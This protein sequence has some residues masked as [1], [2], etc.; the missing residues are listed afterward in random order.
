MDV[1]RRAVWPLAPGDTKHLSEDERLRKDA[2]STGFAIFLILI[3]FVGPAVVLAGGQWLR[4]NTAAT[5]SFGP[6]LDK[7]DGVTSESAVSTTMVVKFSKNGSALAARSSTDTIT[8]DA[9]G[10]YLVPIATTDTNTLGRLRMT[11]TDTSTF[12]SVWQDYMVLPQAV[13]DSLISGTSSLTVIVGQNNDKA[14]YG[15]T[16]AFP[17][18]F[19]AMG[20]S[21]GGAINTVGVVTDSRIANLDASVSSR[22]AA[23]SYT[24]PPSSSDNASA[25][26]AAGTRTLT[27]KSSFTLTSDYDA[28]KTAA[29]AATA[30]STSTWTPTMAGFLDAAISTRLPSS[31]Y[32][33]PPSSS[34]IAGAIWTNGSRSLTDSVT[35]TSAYDAA[36][37]AAQ[38][39]DAMTIAANQ[40]IRNVTGNVAGSVGSVTNSVTLTTA[41]DA[42]KTA[43]QPGDSMT[44]T[45]AYDAAKTCLPASSYTAAPS[46]TDIDSL[47]SANHGAGAWGGGGGGGGSDP[48][49]VNLPGTYTAG[50]AG[51]I[52]GNT[53][54]DSNT[55][56]AFLGSSVPGTYTAGTLAYDIGHNLDATVSSRL[57]A[58]SFTSS[59]T[60]I[61]G[62]LSTPVPGTFPAG[63]LGEIIGNTSSMT[64]IV[65]VLSS[66]S[67]TL[68][69][70]YDAAKEAVSMYD[71]RLAYLDSYVSSCGSSTMSWEALAMDHNMPGTM[72]ALLNG[73]GAG[74]DPLAVST[75]A[76]YAVGTYGYLIKNLLAKEAT[77]LSG[78]S[79]GVI[80]PAITVYQNSDI[81]IFQ[82]DSTTLTISL[83][84][85]WPLTSQTVTL[86]V[87]SSPTSLNTT[88][89]INRVAT[90]TDAAHGIATIGITSTDTHTALTYYYSIFVADTAAPLNKRTA[91][92]GRFIIKPNVL[93]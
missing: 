11:A 90:V 25:T 62:L 35:L 31:S 4:Q 37:T 86:V 60:F 34:T 18:N 68:N 49:A 71:P 41:Y 3:F 51:Y 84:T 32:S 39:G 56:S 79:K 17:V 87:K 50:T 66:G 89:L 82:G 57:P 45:V 48:W 47:L 76:T 29:P 26:W 36:K 92:T 10:Y 73:A 23:A 58:S 93:P 28:A 77:M 24:A 22:L 65:N 53:S 16:Q 21:A 85:A 13:Y 52:I 40:D 75:S 6:F 44:L 91:M 2:N 83:G 69:S 46:E 33:A 70:A 81:S 1:H 88:P 59:A 74:A 54:T 72:G 55:I 14:S 12:C 67:V 43:A 20:I 9:D 30:L 38:A 64:D 42:A 19:A 8:Y 27:D 61:S 78:I 5:I 15:L 63:S 7:T 80:T